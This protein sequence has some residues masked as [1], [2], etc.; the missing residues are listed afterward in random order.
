MAIMR[1]PMIVDSD[2]DGNRTAIPGD[3]GQESELS[4][5]SFLKSISKKCL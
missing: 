3:G 4:D 2:S 5:A 1:T